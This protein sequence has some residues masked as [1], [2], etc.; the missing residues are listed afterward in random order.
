VRTFLL[1]LPKAQ[2]EY[3]KKQLTERQSKE[4]EV[5]AAK[6]A[7]DSKP[8]NERFKGVTSNTQN[9]SRLVPKQ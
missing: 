7:S 4:D 5:R 9:R 8:F 3:Y 2:I 1:N 6:A